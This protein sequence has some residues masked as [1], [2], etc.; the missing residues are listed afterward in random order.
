MPPLR[1][2]W[3]AASAV[4]LVRRGLEIDDGSRWA[5]VSNP[6]NV[7]AVAFDQLLPN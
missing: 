5:L 2:G 1:A 7:L 3:L 6:G 4:A